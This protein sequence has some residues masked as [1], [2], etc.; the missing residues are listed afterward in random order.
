MANRLQFL[1]HV[2]KYF[3]II[4]LPLKKDCKI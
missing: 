3:R 1:Q 2:K 4:F